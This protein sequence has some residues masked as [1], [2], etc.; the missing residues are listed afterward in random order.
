MGAFPDSIELLFQ[1]PPNVTM[2]IGHG[3][4]CY[5][6]RGVLWEWELK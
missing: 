4:S 5:I 2:P 1:H 3:L 6:L